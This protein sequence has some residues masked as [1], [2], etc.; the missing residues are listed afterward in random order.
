MYCYYSDNNLNADGV[1]YNNYALT[2]SRGIAPNGYRIAN[3]ED[4]YKLMTYCGNSYST[5]FEKDVWI[6]AD[7][8][9]T[10]QTNLNLLPIGIRTM[11]TTFNEEATHYT[12]NGYL[13]TFFLSN[14]IHQ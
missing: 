7:E 2:D 12:G 3:R 4:W 1:L 11:K 5:Y 14:Q 8:T 6:G 9:L 13:A 10:G